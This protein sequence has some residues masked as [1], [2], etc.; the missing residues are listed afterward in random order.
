[1]WIPSIE[2]H[3][4]H[5]TITVS[6][7]RPIDIKATDKYLSVA[8]IFVFTVIAAYA[9]VFFGTML[10]AGKSGRHA[11]EQGADLLMFIIENQIFL[12]LLSLLA[13]LIVAMVYIKRSGSRKLISKISFNDERQLFILD[14]FHFYTEKHKEISVS[15]DS[16]DIEIVRILDGKRV[17]EI[18]VHFRLDGR[19][20][21]MI[22]DNDYLWDKDGKKVLAIVSKLKE[23]CKQL[24]VKDR[25]DVSASIGSSFFKR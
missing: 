2:I 11:H 17:N 18:R 9:G 12:I 4:V 3:R 24:Q 13:G 7:S 14:T 15:Y 25:A 8:L 21:A 22:S 23:S 20:V 19:V 5:S 6:P 1:M 10:V 16:A